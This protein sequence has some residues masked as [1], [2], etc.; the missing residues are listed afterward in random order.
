MRS[1][2]GMSSGGNPSSGHGACFCEQHSARDTSRSGRRH[3][4]LVHQLS[5]G[6]AFP[7]FPDGDSGQPVCTGLAN[8]CS[9][10]RGTAERPRCSYT[11]CGDGR[12]V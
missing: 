12:T 6:E 11:M 3:T 1:A 7:R 8:Y 10:S 4:S 5:G 9:E 2:V